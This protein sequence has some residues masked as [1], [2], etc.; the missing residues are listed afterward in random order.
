MLSFL[1]QVCHVLVFVVDY[2]IDADL[3]N[4]VRTCEMLKSHLPLPENP[5]GADHLTHIGVWNVK[6]LN[7][8]SF[9]FGF[10]VLYSFR[11]KS[12][13]SRRFFG[14]GD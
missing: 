3:V 9:A 12:S 11:S 8:T 14:E 5:T 10:L 1:L 6:K 7:F 2:F 13:K 4:L